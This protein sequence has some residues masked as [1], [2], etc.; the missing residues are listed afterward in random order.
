MGGLVNI[1]QVDDDRFS[2]TI[3]ILEKI[4]NMLG[5]FEIEATKTIS[6]NKQQML[7]QYEDAELRVSRYI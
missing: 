4:T 7:E 5:T 1:D 6:K 3:N 2:L